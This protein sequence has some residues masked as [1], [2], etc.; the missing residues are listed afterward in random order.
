MTPELVG[1]EEVARRQA[2]AGA[3]G[4]EVGGDRFDGRKAGE[5]DDMHP[6][7]V[8][9]V[10]PAEVGRHVLA[11]HHH[12][13]MGG[14]PAGV[15]L[16]PCGQLLG[17]EVLGEAML[18]EVRN[19]LHAAEL[20]PGGRA[21]QQ[22]IDLFPR[23]GFAPEGPEPLRPRGHLDAAARQPFEPGVA[24]RRP[25]LF[26]RRLVAPHHDQARPVG[27]GQQAKRL[28]QVADIIDPTGPGVLV[29]V[30]QADGQ[31]PVHQSARAFS[32]RRKPSSFSPCRL[33]T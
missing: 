12:V 33:Q 9:G 18:L 13:A 15:A 7:V 8:L 23:I 1:A 2:V 16:Q 32:P 20:Q 19:P 30:A 11:G 21:H 26:Q 28:D 3:K 22:K 24:G 14:E 29:G 17:R 4:G 6:V 10:M 5:A 27:G 31:G 25:E